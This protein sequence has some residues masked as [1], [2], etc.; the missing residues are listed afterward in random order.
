M[1]SYFSV[2]ISKSGGRDTIEEEVALTSE[3]TAVL[4]D[5]AGTSVGFLTKETGEDEGNV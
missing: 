4:G 1:T 3:V 2:V 5:F